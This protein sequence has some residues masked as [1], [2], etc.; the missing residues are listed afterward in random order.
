MR[1][2]QLISA[3]NAP[4]DQLRNAGRLGG[5]GDPLL[6]R[7]DSRGL[8]PPA[9]N[10]PVAAAAE[11]PPSGHWHSPGRWDA[12]EPQHGWVFRQ[13]AEPP[14]PV[15]S[16]LHLPVPAGRNRFGRGDRT[17]P[18]AGPQE[19]RPESGCDG[20]CGAAGPA[21]LAG[22]WPAVQPAATPWPRSPH[23]SS[24]PHPSVQRR[25]VGL[26]RWRRQLP[27]DRQGLAVPAGPRCQRGGAAIDG[28]HPEGQPPVHGPAETGA[29]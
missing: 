25:S 22:P 21:L 14:A 20:H 8:H 6:R 9:R 2:Q 26:L 12:P 11:S 1:E 24:A 15:R 10:S 29:D 4:P 28:V 19:R 5:G 23:T 13:R 27:A 7:N 18:A 3:G 17:A 16:K